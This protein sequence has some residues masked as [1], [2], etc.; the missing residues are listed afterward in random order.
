MR[1][2]NKIAIITGAS[3]GIG[4]AVATAFAREGASV[5]LCGSRQST[6]DS[7]AQRLEELVPGAKILPLGVD[8]SDGAAIGQMVQSVVDH[9]GRI[10]ILVN[11]AGIT[12][13]KSVYDMTDE[14]FD[15]MLR[16]NLSGPF[17]CIR[18]VAKVMRAN[19]GGSIVNTSSM[20]G[21]Y[22]GK[23]QSAYA[24]SKFGINGLTKS[25]AKELGPDHI[26]VNAVAPGVVATDMVKQS[27]SDEMLAGLRRLTP[28]GRPA[29]T[30]ELA[31][32]Y[33]YLASDEA[34]FTTG[35]IVPV[36]GGI[37]M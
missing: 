20:V 35:A 13:S 14:D 16:V 2:E 4:F 11:N 18:E 7:A 23:L 30:S 34:S 31:G 8:V 29:E 33:V 10:D 25:F 15:G 37:V 28:L 5:A 27:V 32:A 36:D 9:F 24:A 1:L 12:A 17:K 19:G 3:R 22:G 6:A 21:T 26:R